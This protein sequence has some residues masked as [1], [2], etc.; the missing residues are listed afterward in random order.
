MNYHHI[1]YEDRI[2][3]KAY[4]NCGLNMAQIANKIGVHKSTISREIK[5]N[6]G[7]KGYRPKQAHQLAQQRQHQ[8]IKHV[9]FN[10]FVK[11]RV[12]F[13]LR[14]HWSPEQISG[15]LKAN[16][17]IQISHETIYQFIWNDKRNGGDL[18]KYLRHSAKKKKKRYGKKDRRGQIKDRVSIDQRPEIVDKKERIGDWEIDTIIGKNHQG[19]LVSAVE[20]KSQLTCIAHVPKR[21]AELVTQAVISML[22]P[23]KDKVLTITVDNGKEFAQ[24]KTIAEKLEAQLF[25]A[26][27]YCSWERGLNE[28]VNGLIR[29]Y[30]PKKTDLSDVTEQQIFFVQT[31]LNHRPRKSLDF[32]TPYEIFFNLNGC[33]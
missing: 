12:I 31:R 10:E 4:L 6:K 17:R 15:Y 11:E 16:E 18:Y 1:S 13:Y 23:V 9:R 32:K 20:R 3:I 21:E 22:T 30:F 5:R 29:Q 33:I 26:H 24:H 19:A 8:A 7:K 2:Q 25:F 28:Q 27:P 14:L